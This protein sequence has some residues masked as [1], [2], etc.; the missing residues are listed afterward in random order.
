LD[1][2]SAQAAAWHLQNGLTWEELTNKI[3]AKHLNGSVEPYFTAVNL[4]RALAA[5][6]VAK[7]RAEKLPEQQSP[8]ATPAVTPFRSSS[9]DL[10]TKQ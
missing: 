4:Q 8:S 2:H 1:Q 9:E 5:S 7:E 6:R 10:A 3:G